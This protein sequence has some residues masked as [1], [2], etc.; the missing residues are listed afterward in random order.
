MLPDPFLSIQR[1][2]TTFALRELSLALGRGLTL[3][4]AGPSGS[5]KSTLARCLAR[6]EEPLA[7]E[8]LLEGREL[9]K[10]NRTDIQLVPQEPAAS[11]NPRFT[12]EEILVEPLLIQQWGDRQ[13][14][15]QRALELMELTGLPTE[16][17]GR[18]ALEFSGGERQRLAI[19][20]ALMAAPKLL[21]LDE[22]FSGVDFLTQAQI[23]S[24][25]ADLR[26]RLSLTCI[27][28]SHDLAAVSRL[29]DEIAVMDCG[30][31]VEHG[32]VGEVLSNPQHA[33]TKELLAAA[34]S[35]SL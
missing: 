1:L 25:V 13:S 8:I 24:L 27:L 3:G 29:S 5:G 12:A 26:G 6:I 15:L 11:L 32:K 16:A 10:C 19:A 7:G 33:R 17:I 18:R 34:L 35:L 28:I 30:R 4:L 31:I 9:A 22:S 2:S 20:R 23:C 14:R 21:I